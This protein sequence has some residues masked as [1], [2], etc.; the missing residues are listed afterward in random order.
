MKCSEYIINFLSG[1]ISSLIGVI[2]AFFLA[3]WQFKRESRLANKKAEIED[4]IFKDAILSIFTEEIVNNLNLTK[5]TIKYI[6]HAKSFKKLEY[7]LSNSDK[8][9]FDTY[10][11]LQIDLFKHRNIK[12][13]KEIIDLYECFYILK[14][15]PSNL[16][17][18]QS[19]FEKIKTIYNSNTL[20]QYYK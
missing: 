16:A 19:H 9:K 4:N 11:K 13:V 12:E 17:L 6:S 14:R 1:C 5:S 2:G 3:H 10:K 15:F 7:S 18:K 8:L 20:L